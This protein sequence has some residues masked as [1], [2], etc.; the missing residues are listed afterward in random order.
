MM[1]DYLSVPDFEKW[2]HYKDRT[3]PWI[4]LH[5]DLLHDYD[6]NKLLDANKAHLLLIWILASQ[7]ENKIP[8]DAKFVQQKIGATEPVDL[9]LLIELGFL[10]AHVAK[11]KRVAST[12]LASCKQVAMRETETET[13]TE[14]EKNKQKEKFNLP[15]GIPP[16]RWQK[17]EAD[18]KQKGKP[19]TDNART[20]NANKLVDYAK[21]GFDIKRIMDETS[22]HGWDSFYEPKPSKFLPNPRPQGKGA[23]IV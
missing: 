10:E 1:S 14:T 12:P 5:R 2:Q 13:E 4:K 11:R 22:A 20:L 17:F 21:R 6:F 7:L 16:D 9:K 19:L 23:I 8:N 15:E 18:R 3:P